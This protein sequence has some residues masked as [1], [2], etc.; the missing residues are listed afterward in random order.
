MNRNKN[1]IW[2]VCNSIY[3]S[4]KY[5]KF[6]FFHNGEKPRDYI[7]KKTKHFVKPKLYIYNKLNDMRQIK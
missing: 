3:F 1:K 2:F 7:L 5:I 6:L 4:L